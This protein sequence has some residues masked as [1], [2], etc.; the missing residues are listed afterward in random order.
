MIITIKNYKTGANQ[1]LQSIQDEA[2]RDISQRSWTAHQCH[3]EPHQR[4]RMGPTSVSVG[5]DKRDT[6]NVGRTNQIKHKLDDHMMPW[7]HMNIQFTL[8]PARPKAPM[9]KCSENKHVKN[10][11][12][13]TNSIPMKTEY[14]WS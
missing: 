3:K 7:R 13:I 11:D 1:G 14:R 4:L 10:F 5:N 6:P 12:R 8:N 2:G 9:R